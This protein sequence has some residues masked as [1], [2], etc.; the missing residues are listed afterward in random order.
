M[1]LEV[2]LI[3]W[4]DSLISSQARRQASLASPYNL[5]VSCGY[6]WCAFIPSSCMFFCF[7]RCIN[8]H[9]SLWS[10]HQMLSALSI[11]MSSANENPLP[12]PTPSKK[13]NG[14]YWIIP[15]HLDWHDS[16]YHMSPP[17]WVQ[18][19]DW[20]ENT[21]WK[22]IPLSSGQASVRQSVWRGGEPH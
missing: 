7:S 16:D 20:H 21:G 14:F 19:L 1:D 8:S 9:P 5:T 12:C 10:C 4:I 11:F 6:I 3:H 13:T 15:I 2:D 17:H 18:S 22:S